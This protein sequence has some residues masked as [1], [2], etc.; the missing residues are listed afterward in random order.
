MWKL[1]ILYYISIFL[2]YILIDI[3]F[4][5]TKFRGKSYGSYWLFQQKPAWHI[6]Y[7]ETYLKKDSMKVN[8]NKTLCLGRKHNIFVACYALKK[9][10]LEHQWYSVQVFYSR[11]RSFWDWNLNSRTLPRNSSVTYERC[12]KTYML[13]EC[14]YLFVFFN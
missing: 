13:H 12:A 9:K 4:K 3:F 11:T 1:T 6:I 2:M 10:L 14:E 5:I 8:L 7:Y